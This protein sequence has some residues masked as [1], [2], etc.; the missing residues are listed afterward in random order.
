M[1]FF[2]PLQQGIIFLKALAEAEAGIEHDT[3]AFHSRHLGGIGPIAKF[4]LHLH[5]DI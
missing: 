2:E 1:K 5:H 3:L 4:P